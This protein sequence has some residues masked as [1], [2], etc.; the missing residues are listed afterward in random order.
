MIED[1]LEILLITYN[2]CQFLEKT[3][4]TLKNSPFA[5]CK[6]TILDNCSTDNTQEICS[7]YRKVFPHYTI[8]RHKINIS[9]NPNYLRAVEMSDSLYTWILCDDDDF[10]FTDVSDVIDAIES[11][12]YDLI[13]VGS[14][15]RAEWAK[16]LK[17]TSRE[18]IE[19]GLLYH[20]ELTFFPAIIFKTALF[21]SECIATGYNLIGNLYPPFE[22]INKSVRD[23]FK[24]YVSKKLIVIRNDINIS[25]YSPLFGYTAWI[26]CCRTI[27]DKRL[28]YKTI[29]QA[30]ALR[31]F[32][33]SL[34]F[35]IAF[36][37]IYNPQDFYKKLAD[38]IVT[39]SWW[40]RMKLLLLLPLF[41]IPIP[42]SLLLFARRIVYKL[43]NIKDIPPVEIL[44]S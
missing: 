36:E 41:F 7:T 16:G 24:V 19:R 28:R 18:L 37:K 34:A 25:T 39:F 15:N 38:I 4:K 6:I 40:Q 14:P 23:N 1:R 30:T 13:Y 17:T 10:D 21:D 12:E 9:G 27:P 29:D 44:N 26:N 8:I 3:L 11:E 22:F 5:Q 42:K 43:L 32:Y 31:G 35:W 20:I 2:R 33:K